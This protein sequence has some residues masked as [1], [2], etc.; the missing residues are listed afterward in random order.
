MQV[1]PMNRFSKSIATDMS[2]ELG[3]INKMQASQNV[4]QL[5]SD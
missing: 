5:F 4:I 3:Y 2:S 1:T